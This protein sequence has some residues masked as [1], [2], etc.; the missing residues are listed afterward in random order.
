MHI[1]F[2]SRGYPSKER[3]QNGNFE[4]DQAEGLAKLGHKVSM[5]SVDVG[6]EFLPKEYGIQRIEKN[7]VLSYHI[8]LIPMKFFVGNGI[9]RKLLDIQLDYLY[10]KVVK[11]LGKPDV[12]Y[13]HYLWNMDWALFLK[14]K[15]HIPLVGIEHWSEIGYDDIKPFIAQ[16]A[17]RI[18]PQVDG[19][20]TVSH[21]LQNNIQKQ[22]NIQSNVVFDTIHN[23][24]RM[25]KIK[26]P[27]DGIVRFISIGSLIPRKGYDDLIDA[28]SKCSLPRDKWK[29]TIIG[30]GP[31]EKALHE[32][33]V[34]NSLDKNIVLAGRR[35][36]AEVVDELNRSDIFISSSHLETFGVAALEALGCGLPVLAVDS[37]GPREFMTDVNG[38]ICEDTIEA[39]RK[40][41]EYM[42]AHYQEFDRQAI[43]DDCLAR[44]SSEV[45]AKQLT[46]IFEDVINKRSQ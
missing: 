30:E 5:I 34:Q 35:S 19:L 46:Q 20:I 3:P 14:K 36:K 23:S 17:R 2:I 31:E 16:N 21:S 10:K 22:F 26:R 15:Y 18:Y 8:F 33:I 38:R 9:F 41:I 27:D 43:A 37:E 12:I 45:I 6:R 25:K 29:L 24:V 11:E 13:P 39:R 4:V 7:G 44:F 42:Y 40:G 28:F 32:Q 1:L